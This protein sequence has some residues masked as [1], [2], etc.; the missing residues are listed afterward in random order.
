MEIKIQDKHLEKIKNIVDVSK[1]VQFTPFAINSETIENRI[2]NFKDASD[3]KFLN[4]GRFKI[5]TFS[6][7]RV[8]PQNPSQII[9]VNSND[10]KNI[11]P[12]EPGV[13]KLYAFE[14]GICWFRAS[15][16]IFLSEHFQFHDY[17]NDNNNNN[18]EF[19]TMI[20][21]IKN[22]I[23]VSL[24]T[25]DF[26]ATLN[27]DVTEIYFN[28]EN[29]LIYLMYLL[30]NNTKTK[31]NMCV[32][33][34]W[35]TII[36]PIFE[37]YFKDNFKHF[38]VKKNLM[39]H[40]HE[41]NSENTGEIEKSTEYNINK[42]NGSFLKVVE[43][44]EILNCD[45][46]DY[47][48]MRYESQNTIKYKIWELAINSLISCKNKL[49]LYMTYG[50]EYYELVGVVITNNAK[51][52]KEAKHFHTLSI[53]K[54][55]ENFGGDAINNFNIYENV[56]LTDG[57]IKMNCYAGDE[58]NFNLNIGFRE[59]IYK[60]IENGRDRV[61]KF[62]EF[63]NLMK[64]FNMYKRLNSYKTVF[65]IKLLSFVSSYGYSLYNSGLNNNPEVKDE[66][67][68]VD[69]L[70]SI[71]IIKTDN[72]TTT[73][74]DDRD[75]YFSIILRLHEKIK[76]NHEN[77]IK[78]NINFMNMERDDKVV[79]TKIDF[80]IP[81]NYS[82]YIQKYKNTILMLIKFIKYEIRGVNNI[83]ENV[84]FR[85]LIEIHDANIDMSTAD[86]YINTSTFDGVKYTFKFDHVVYAI[87]KLEIEQWRSLSP[88]FNLFVLSFVPSIKF[89]S[90]PNIN[91]FG[92]DNNK[93]LI[94]MY[95][96]LEN[97]V[98]YYNDYSPEEFSEKIPKNQYESHGYFYYYVDNDIMIKDGGNNH[99]N[100]I[101]IVYKNNIYKPYYLK[102]TKQIFI[103]VEC[104]KGNKKGNKK[105]YPKYPFK[106]KYLK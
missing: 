38:L 34:S 96:V 84:V 51:N 43:K 68:I 90:S 25:T 53:T 92:H 69:Y 101:G 88:E 97:E 56:L 26:K 17:N 39:S 20:K 4:F 2:I 9:I 81:Y 78:D 95:D 104:K 14:Y 33:G 40:V 82:F 28:E 85:K 76:S 27:D 52:I 22:D 46:I 44:K 94:F 63:E 41:I 12:V 32:T 8:Q 49:V 100:K 73:I 23:K 91:I 79:Y 6:S 45:F 89:Y 58:M 11:I 7:N 59:C 102:K 67:N 103:F 98:Y 80:E 66:E 3:K 87:F 60:K 31:V 16:Q 21:K 18:D 29:V 70:G 65:H 57:E 24:F 10:I 62:K 106:L 105:I 15:I 83:I 99:N 36:L 1:A 42:T 48:L 77:V 54:N 50:E 71:R 74:D 37:I 55:K 72:I 93:K 35:N 19:I 13:K 47:I 61:T 30:A 86:F 64:S 75:N 5:N